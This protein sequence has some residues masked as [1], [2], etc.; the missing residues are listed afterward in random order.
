MAF[1]E[2]VSVDRLDE[3]F[4]SDWNQLFAG[5]TATCCTKCGARFAVFFQDADGRD[6]GEYPA[7]I[8]G[9]ISEDCWAGKHTPEFVIKAS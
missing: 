2:S 8:Q 5:T 1:Y 3:L 4:R 7:E 6:N 9:M